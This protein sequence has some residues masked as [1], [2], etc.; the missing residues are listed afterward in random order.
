MRTA[1]ATVV[2]AL[3]AA[4]AAMAAG[5]TRAPTYILNGYSFSGVPGVNAAEMEAK[6]KFHAGARVTRAEIAAEAA[7]LARELKARHMEGHLFTS[8]AESG[9]RVWVIFDLLNPDAD[10]RMGQLESQNFQGASHVSP[11]ALAAVTD[12]KNGE[13]L[14]PQKLGAARRAIV[15]AYAKSMPGKKIFIKAKLV[16]R[17][18]KTAVT[19]IIA[20]PK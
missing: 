15:A 1:R 20:E 19:W 8:T 3:F 12:L 13:R 5:D 16:T 9:G 2:A 6:L 14:S 7:V 18:G 4:G 10:N 17:G 11:S